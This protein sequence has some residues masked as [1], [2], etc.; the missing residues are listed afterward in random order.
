MSEPTATPGRAWALRLRR[1][2]MGALLATVAVLGGVY[3]LSGIT[4][5]KPE[6]Q[7]LVLRFGKRTAVPLL[8]G[9]HYTLPYPIDRVFVLKPNEV[10]NVTVGLSDAYAY[11]KSR[12]GAAS[13]RGS[14]SGPNFLTGDENIIHLELNVQYA[15]SDAA[16]YLFRASDTDRLVV[17][18][19][20][21]ALAADVARS[22]V[23]EILTSGR[24]MLLA[25]VKK[26]AQEILDSM[27]AGVG[28]MSLNLAKA[29]PP[30]D[31][32]EAFKDVASALEDRD[33]FINEAN[34]HYNEMLPKARG[35]AT[36]IVHEA[37]AD[38]NGSVK[39]ATGETAR[40]LQTLAELELSTN[41]EL[42]TLR[43]YL[44]T[45]EAVLPRVRKYIVET[46]SP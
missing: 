19:C 2:L 16:A 39:R 44:E 34:G 7:A 10:K 5:I 20:E 38:K 14:N 29:A 1:P 27:K 15:V 12:V 21:E 18:A 31:V 36:E 24:H 23:D 11:A 25:Q 9:T 30:R 41:P 35:E 3:V 22:P 43:L 42:S 46:A 45:M 4:V 13:F 37:K 8:P 33:R 28:L 26:D 17:L 40:F 6:E 32:A